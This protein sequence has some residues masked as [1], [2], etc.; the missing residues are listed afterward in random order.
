MTQS[1][2]APVETHPG[3]N[4]QGRSSRASS[5]RRMFY[6]AFDLPGSRADPP[7]RAGRLPDRLHGHTVVLRRERESVRRV[8]QLRRRCSANDSTFT[9]IRNNVIWVIVAPVTC[10]VLGLI[11]AVLLDK[12]RWS[13]AFKLIIFMPMAISMLAAGVIFRTMFQENPNLGVVNATLVADQRLR[14]P[15]SPPIPGANVRPDSGLVVQN[16]T[17]A[18]DGTVEPGAQQNFPLVGIRADTL[19]GRSHSGQGSPR[20]PVRVRSPARYGSTSSAAAA[21]RTARSRTARSGLPGIKVDAVAQDGTIAATAQTDAQG[22]YKLAGLAAGSYTDRAARARTST[23]GY[24]GVSWLGDRLHHRRSSSSATS[25]SG[26]A[27]RWC[28]IA[29][30]LSAIDRSLQEAAR[31]DGANEWQVFRR[32]TGT[33]AVA[34]ARRRLRDSHHQRAQDLRPGLR[35]TTR[36]I[37]TRG[38]RHRR[39]DVDGVVRWR[40]QPGPRQR[41]R[42]P[43]ADPGAARR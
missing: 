13:T 7:R 34:G 32:I 1:A 37:E 33:A 41:A 29:S 28:M 23:Q 6:I 16:G 43:A 19:P 10:T 26:P 15:T 2:V 35:D 22:R 4:G 38:Q 11:F 12:I 31:M 9:A 36:R 3:R 14:S 30:G 8:R 40:Q 25:G 20:R 5:R 17:I 27:S 42:D 24:Q 21:A 18:S 39:R